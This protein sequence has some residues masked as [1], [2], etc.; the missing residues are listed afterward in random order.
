MISH[1]VSNKLSCDLVHSFISLFD[2]NLFLANSRASSELTFFC[3][4]FL[5]WWLFSFSLKI[6]PLLI[7]FVLSLLKSED[8]LVH[9]TLRSGNGLAHLRP[10]ALAAVA[11]A[12]FSSLS[13]YRI[14]IYDYMLIIECCGSRLTLSVVPLRRCPECPPTARFRLLILPP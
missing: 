13:H 9:W 4:A 3:S 8:E 5:D 12:R 1:F 2:G 7:Y 14:L 11:R 10:L 6:L